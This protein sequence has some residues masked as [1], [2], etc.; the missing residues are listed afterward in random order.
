MA[1]AG[2]VEYELIQIVNII[3][4]ARFVTISMRERLVQE[5]LSSKVPLRDLPIP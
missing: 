3:N 4:D 2:M 5:R 1:T